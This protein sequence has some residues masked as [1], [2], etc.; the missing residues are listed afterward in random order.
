MVRQARTLQ[1]G[2]S[3]KFVVPTTITAEVSSDV[4]AAEIVC[5]IQHFACCLS[6]CH[7]QS[8]QQLMAQAQNDSV[9]QMQTAAGT[10]T[11]TEQ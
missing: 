4:A 7:Q 3:G 10:I 5:C 6:E 1:Q 11:P 8:E 2:A 9:Q